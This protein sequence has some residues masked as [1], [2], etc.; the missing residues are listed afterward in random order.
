MLAAY[1]AERG[2]WDVE[3]DYLEVKE[4]GLDHLVNDQPSAADDLDILS[5]TIESLDQDEPEA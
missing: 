5:D 2:E 4:E 1:E 3:D